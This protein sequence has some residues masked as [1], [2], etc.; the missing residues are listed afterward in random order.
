MALRPDCLRLVAWRDAVNYI[1]HGGGYFKGQLLP[2]IQRGLIILV[3]SYS[4]KGS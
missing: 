3:P 4:R 2:I 1:G